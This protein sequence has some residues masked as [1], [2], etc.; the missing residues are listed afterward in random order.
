VEGSEVATLNNNDSEVTILAV[1]RA[2]VILKLL[3]KTKSDIGVRDISRELGY[4]PAVTQKI[5]NTFKA[6]SFVQQD[7]D[8]QRYQLGI[9]ALNVGLAVLEQTDLLKVARPMMIELTNKT[10]ETT[11][12]ALQDEYRTVY[13]DRVKSPHPIRMDA[14]IGAHR[15]MNCTAV[16]K[17]L[18]AYGPPGNV[19][20]AYDSGSF[21][22]S[23]NKSIVDL[24]MFEME[25]ER[26]REQKYAIDN[27]E[28]NSEAMCVAAPIFGPNGQIYAALTTSGPSF[29]MK[30]RMSE[31]IDLVKEKAA[32]ISAQ[33]GHN[34]FTQT[35][36][37]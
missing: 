32:E 25:L 19:S 27:E 9:G 23:T 34:T 7:L 4:S 21:E 5:L 2:L 22:K 11:F 1:D 15:P 28:Y 14:E 26:V 20:A 6:H 13:I 29:R 3:A 12:L 33:L 24:K 17:I 37:N 31:I 30:H 18:L 36:T 10:E 35:N 16:G 8:T